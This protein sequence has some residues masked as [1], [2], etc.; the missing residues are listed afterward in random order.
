[1]A[2]GKRNRRETI[3]SMVV[4]PDLF[5]AAVWQQSDVTT[6]DP[7]ADTGAATETTSQVDSETS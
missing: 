1:M 6:P 5:D 4:D 2:R 7:D 3:R